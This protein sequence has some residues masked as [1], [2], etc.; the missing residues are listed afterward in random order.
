MDSCNNCKS[1]N[2]TQE[3]TTG[4]FLNQ[5]LK[6]HS[7]WWDHNEYSYST[8]RPKQ[9]TGYY[10][11]EQGNLI[12]P[13][14][15]GGTKHDQGKP[16]LSLLSKAG[17]DGIARAFMFGQNKYGRYNYLQ[18]MDWSRLIAAADRHISAFNDGQDFDEDSKLNHL[19]H[20][21]ACIMMLIEFYDKQLG[22][23]NR[24]KALPKSTDDRGPALD[25]PKT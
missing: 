24:Y 14:E 20:A 19:Y 2:F 1:T 18:G 8:E 21:G 12:A 4:G 16:D 6:C 11:D 15:T 25:N 9:L 3:M 10:M 22:T 17:K 23:D 7:K 13:T 5:C